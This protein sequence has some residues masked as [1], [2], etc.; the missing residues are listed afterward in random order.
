MGL[1][2]LLLFFY[3]HLVAGLAGYESLILF[4][5]GIVLIIAEFFLPGAIA[6]ILGAAAIIGSLLIAGGNIFYMGISI[7][8]AVLVAIIGM[9]IMVKVLG[10][11]MK[12]FKKIVLSDSTSTEKRICIK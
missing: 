1:T 7:I 2:A 6:G 10:K 12:I 5:I 9:I 11:R 3:G 8:I 4:I